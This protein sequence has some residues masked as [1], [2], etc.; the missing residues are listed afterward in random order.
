M[1]DIEKVKQKIDLVDLM[2]EYIPLKKA[3]RNFKAL[4]PFHSEKTPSLV[5]SPERQIW[6]CFGG[7]AKGGDIFTF[8]MEYDKIEFPE[9][10]RFLA[11]KAGVTLNAP[12]FKSDQEKKRETIYELN[13]LAAHFYHYLLTSHS[14]GKKALS[15]LTETRKVTLK[16]INTFN[17][18]YAPND[19]HALVHYLFK[20]KQYLPQ[21]L[22]DAGLVTQRGKDLIDFFRHRIIFP[23]YDVRGNVIAFSGRTIDANTSGPKYINT[24]ET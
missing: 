13:H 3:G 15:Y 9:A 14:V 1:D 10:L 6:H 19:S 22:L 2:Q 7:C 24:K 21:A 16:L 17:I 8:V 5:V 18:G 11:Q 12:V 4:C 20:K 23:L